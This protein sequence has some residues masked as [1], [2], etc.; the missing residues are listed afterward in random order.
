M[1]TYICKYIQHLH[2][3]TRKYVRVCMYVCSQVCMYVTT[4][5]T[6]HD[7]WKL[8]QTD[9]HSY[10]TRQARPAFYRR[11]QALISLRALYTY[12]KPSS[13]SLSAFTTINVRLVRVDGVDSRSPRR[14]RKTLR[15]RCSS[16]LCGR[17]F[18]D[19]AYGCGFAGLGARQS[20]KELIDGLRKFVIVAI[21]IIVMITVIS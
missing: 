6:L 12:C 21:I 19:C 5:C 8:N 3:H 9:T 15:L 17:I 7:S 1:H 13:I 16:R 18:C 2:T 4:I 11:G 14:S 20:G 10:S